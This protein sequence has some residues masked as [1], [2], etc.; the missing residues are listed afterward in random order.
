MVIIHASPVGTGLGSK[1]VVG[2]PRMIRDVKQTK[3]LLLYS[4]CLNLLMNYGLVI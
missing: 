3:V 4:Q 2:A 1:K